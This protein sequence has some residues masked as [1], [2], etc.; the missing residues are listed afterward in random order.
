MT[1]LEQYLAMLAYLRHSKQEPRHFA[2]AEHVPVKY[3]APMFGLTTVDDNSWL[4]G[5]RAVLTRSGQPWPDHEPGL[6]STWNA[7]DGAHYAI[8]EASVPPP[9]SRPWAPGDAPA[10]AHIAVGDPGGSISASAGDDAHLAEVTTKCVYH[11]GDAF[12]KMHHT[13]HCD[14]ADEHVAIDEL[15]R[16]LPDRTFA[17]PAVLYHARY[18]DRYFLVTSQVPGEQAE[19]LWWGLDDADKDHYAELTAQACMEVATLT[20]SDL[21]VG[22]DGSA[23]ESGR[24]RQSLTRRD[25]PDMLANCRTLNLDVEAP[26]CLFQ[27]DMGP[28]NVIIDPHSRTVGIVD[29]QAADYVPRE[30]IGISFARALSMLHDPPVPEGYQ[31]KDYARRVWEALQRRGFGDDGSAWLSWKRVDRQ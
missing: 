11:I 22:I 30:W 13:V 12:I 24:F 17:L 28:T 18:D 16:R 5:D 31:P 27:E 25:K 15:R 26:F 3:R 6:I 2:T 10:L 19:Q 14:S 8:L 1:P 9:A 20:S 7:S 4:I 23:P 29:W 21:G